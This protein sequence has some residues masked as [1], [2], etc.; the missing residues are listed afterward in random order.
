MLVIVRPRTGD[1]LGL[2]PKHAAD[3][4]VERTDQRRIVRRPRRL[5]NHQIPQIER[6]ARCRRLDPRHELLDFRPGCLEAFLQQKPAIEYRAAHV[7]DTWRLDAVDALAAFDAVD[8]D[9]RVARGRRHDRNRGLP[10]GQP[11]RQLG[12]HVL[13]QPAHGLDGA[14]AQKRH[15]PVRDPAARRHFKPVHAAVADADAIDIKRLRNDHVIGAALR[16]PAGFGEVGDAGKATALLV[17]R[18]ADFDGSRQ[19]NARAPDRLCRKHRRG[20]ACF[21]VARTAAEDLPVAHGA[22][23]RIHRPAAARR[24]DVEV[25]VQVH[26]RA[27]PTPPGADHVD[28][29][30]PRR[31]LGPAFRGDVLHSKAAPPE[32]AADKTRTR[33]V[34]VAR[35]IH[36]RNADEIDHVLHDLIGGPIDFG[37]DAVGVSH[38]ANDNS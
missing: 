20:N 17:D 19:P 37:N 22:G 28:T 26:D 23:K 36:R 18:S 13:E 2:A 21:H 3:R 10:R 35:R 25:P 15:A 5:D 4:G 16:Q 1:D 38:R 9:G 32:I 29:R 34:F 24:H 7:G 14:R 27:R 31:V 30:V 33:L 6:D 12:A 11:R 8:V